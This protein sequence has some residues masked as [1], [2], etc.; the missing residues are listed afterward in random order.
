MANVFHQSG[1][2]V[3]CI[4][5]QS[6]ANVYKHLIESMGPTE[7][8]WMLRSG[9]RFFE[10]IV[11][12]TKGPVSVRNIIDAIK[13]IKLVTGEQIAVYVRGHDE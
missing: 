5:W 1:Y 8:N 13:D 2:R 6:F 7:T 10:S 3:H 4:F 12:A 11:D 9:A